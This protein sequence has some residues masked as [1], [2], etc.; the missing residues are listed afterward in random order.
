MDEAALVAQPE[1]TDANHRIARPA[2]VGLI[3]IG[4]MAALAPWSH[5]WMARRTSH[6]SVWSL[7][8][9]FSFASLL[10]IGS[11]CSILSIGSFA[12][13][14]SI[15]SSGSILGLGSSLRR[16]ARYKDI[17]RTMLRS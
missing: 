17:F 3:A 15:G 11:A 6:R 2:I 10:S 16:P 4:T 14:L 13:I 8:S 12:S 1:C 5:N 7:W 9:A